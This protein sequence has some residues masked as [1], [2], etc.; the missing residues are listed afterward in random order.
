MASILK[1]TYFYLQSC[2]ALQSDVTI[3]L[4]YPVRDNMHYQLAYVITLLQMI[5][6]LFL[7]TYSHI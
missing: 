5:S 6:S 7:N 3:L 4:M 1:K 2:V